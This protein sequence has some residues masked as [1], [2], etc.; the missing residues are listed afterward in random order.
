MTL[1]GVLIIAIL[2]A[3]VQSNLF[4]EIDDRIKKL[5]LK[6]HKSFERLSQ[7]IDEEK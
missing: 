2:L 7:Q 4:R 1:V 6:M 5:E 3:L